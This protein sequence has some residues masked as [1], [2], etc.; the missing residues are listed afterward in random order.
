MKHSKSLSIVVPCFNEQ[1]NIFKVISNIKKSLKLSKIDDYE[2][3]IINDGSTDK[4]SCI[5]KSLTD[6]K[7]RIIDNKKNIGLGNA[8]M[9]GYV[10]AKKKYCM[11]VPGDNT[12]PTKGL[13]MIFKKINFS[14]NE[15]L[16]PYVEN[17]QTRHIL[18]LFLSILIL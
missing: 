3:I 16:I 2:I 1:K 17:N 13:V 18:R 6:K 9:K 7:I 10:V 12:H 15:L 11:Y 8:V 4:T 14:K 5:I